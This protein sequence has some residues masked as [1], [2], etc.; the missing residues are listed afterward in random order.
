[1]VGKSV[2]LDVNDWNEEVFKFLTT[3]FNILWETSKIYRRDIFVLLE[4]AHEFIPR[5]QEPRLATSW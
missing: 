5:E 1:M 3:F 4:E 2:V